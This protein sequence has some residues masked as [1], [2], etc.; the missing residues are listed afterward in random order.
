MQKATN[1]IR[2]DDGQALVEFAMVLPLLLVVL[3]GCLEF[4]R[5]MN[6]WL[7]ENRLAN[8]LARAAS[9][10]RYPAVNDAYLTGRGT[11]KEL[12]S[13][14]SSVSKVTV[15]RCSPDGTANVGD[16]VRVKVTSTYSVLPIL[17][18]AKASIPITGQAD[19]RV[20]VKPTTAPSA[21]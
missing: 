4:G 20:E 7:N 11:P 14:S 5:L 8:E 13:G 6:Y 19:M 16:R 9:V 21:C 1:R 10:D 17:G 2:R 12:V 18:L 15:T 3:F